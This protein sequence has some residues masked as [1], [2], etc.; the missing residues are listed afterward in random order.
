MNGNNGEVRPHQPYKT[1]HF[2]QGRV[3][4]DLMLIGEYNAGKSSIIRR[5]VDGTFD[6]SLCYTIGCSFYVK[7][8]CLDRSDIKLR[9]WD[10]S[11]GE[12]YRGPSRSEYRHCHGVI[13]V[14]DVTNMKSF[15]NIAS[16]WLKNIEQNGTSDLVVMIV[17]T[18][19]DLP[20]RQVDYVT[21]KKY[22]DRLNVPL[23]EISSL[24]GYGIDRAIMS[25]VTMAL[26][27]IIQNASSI[28]EGEYVYAKRKTDN[29]CQLS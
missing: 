1:V 11:G 14:Y 18:K 12:R 25:A 20:G 16:I 29:G 22:A 19:C 17:G 2:R 9:L 8:V 26:D 6:D 21:A 7:N 13:I 23:M 5:F 27:K 24:T 10:T 4:V 3:I 15:E 28:C